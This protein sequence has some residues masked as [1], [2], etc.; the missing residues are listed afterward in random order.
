[1]A[2]TASDHGIAPP[3]V[4]LLPKGRKPST[5]ITNHMLTWTKHDIIVVANQKNN[6]KIAMQLKNYQHNCEANQNSQCLN[7][8]A[9]GIL[10]KL[11][12]WWMY[13]VKR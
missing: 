5:S 3:N 9:Y 12:S 13:N 2:S 8:I 11:K 1:M 6:H 4:T 7:L 10:E